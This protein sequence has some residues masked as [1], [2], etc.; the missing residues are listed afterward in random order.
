MNNNQLFDEHIKE[1]LQDYNP[2][3]HPRIWE[4]IASERKK[5]RPAGF[6]LS[7]LKGRKM[8]LAAIII[9][10]ASGSGAYLVFHQQTGATPSGNT[11]AANI[12]TAST[13]N[14]GNRNENVTGNGNDHTQQ[15]PLNATV[16]N[17]EN[18]ISSTGATTSDKGATTTTGT[19]D[20]DMN[21]LSSDARNK[22][23]QNRGGTKIKIRAGNSGEDRADNTEINT[24]KNNNNRTGTFADFGPDNA[25][26]PDDDPY[27][28]LSLMR[29]HFIKPESIQ[30]EKQT[31]LFQKRPTVNIN[32]PGCPSIEKNAAGNKT[33][34]EVYGGPDVAF[35]SMSDTGN[36]VY[37]QKR[38]ESTKFSS[39]YSAGIRYTKVFDN[40]MSIRT[41]INYSQ[42]NEKFTYVQG[43]LVQITYIINAN[44]D[45]TG[46]YIT[47]GTRYKT[48]INRFRTIDVPLLVGYELGNGK[49][50]A[51]INAGVI[52]NAYSWQKGDVLDTAFKPVSITTGKGNSP[53]QF[54]TN[55]GTGLMISSSVYYKL[56]DKLHILLEP[57]FRYN[58]SPMSNEKFTLTQKYNT[59]GVRLGIRLDL[60]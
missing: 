17:N 45:T 57:Y 14:S 20:K 40:G 10:L 34:I 58:L 15:Q 22:S 51:N 50:H 6:W 52:I 39:A 47:T 35:R 19:M 44:G 49:I 32:L 9:L 43:N 12:S 37:L 25:D 7:L 11:S 27:G 23:Y 21:T 5:R 38:K 1:Q 8:L 56:N 2:V 28:L 18:N 42:I 16:S 53:Y 46:S 48:T 54:K 36:S 55:I 13:H 60:H 29:N 4:H 26:K 33:Y 3:V 31:V 41:G 59:A 30:S 24:T